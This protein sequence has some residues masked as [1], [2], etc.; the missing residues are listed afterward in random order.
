MRKRFNVLLIVA[1]IA[2]LFLVFFGINAIANSSNSGGDDY[3]SNRIIVKFKNDIKP[4]EVIRVPKGSVI[5]KVKEYQAKANV[6]YAEPDYR[7]LALGEPNDT[8]YSNQWAL[9]NTGQIIYHGSGNPDDPVSANAIGSGTQ[10]ADTD[11]YE[12]WNGFSSSTWAQSTTTSVIVAIV[13]SGVD[14][15]HPD[16]KDKI[17][18]GTDYI[19]NDGEPDDVYGHGTHVAGITAAETNNGT[20][21]AGIAFPN[22]IKILAIRVLDENGMGY[23][24][25]IANG[26]REA[27]DYGAKNGVKV[28]INLSLGGRDSQ[29][30]KDAVDYAWN[31]GALLAAAAGN[32]GGGRKYYPASYDDVISVAATDYNDD[33]ASFSNFNDQVEV[34]APGVNVFS[35]FPTYPFTI[36]SKYGRSEYYDVG[37]GTS[38]AVPH[39]VGLAALLFDQDSNRSNSDIRDIIDKTADDKGALG[40]DKHYGYGRINIE[41][42]LTGDFNAPTPQCVQDGRYC[43]CNGKCDKFETNSTCPLDCPAE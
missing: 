22:N 36:Q 10:D 38:M 7:I 31:K 28:A 37:S 23:T 40:W 21:I 24:S 32:D 12:T 29:T 30:L 18:K 11:W 19:D 25:D 34:A 27:A 6:I 14:L 17:I 5:R 26:I 2:G 9:N 16:L 33:I 1:V 42:A 43:N 13:D 39:V 4:F 20:G 8:A 3:A 41:R 15:G 35:T